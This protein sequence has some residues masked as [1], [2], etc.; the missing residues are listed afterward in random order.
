M[1]V[2]AEACEAASRGRRAQA[3]GALAWGL[4]LGLAGPATADDLGST[5]ITLFDGVGV[6]EDITEYALD[7]DGLT[8]TED[9]ILGLAIG[10]AIG[11]LG[12]GLSLDVETQAVYHHGRGSFIELG[13]ALVAR[14]QGLSLPEWLGGV[15][16]IDGFSIGTG[17]TVT[18]AIPPLE[19]DRGRIS[20]VLNQVVVEFLGGEPADGPLRPI[21][22]VH[23]RSGIFGLIEG[24]VGGSDYIGEGLQLR[25]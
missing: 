9:R 16:L 24:I 3:A 12:D 8:E 15:R 21:G 18:T 20:H 25:F 17:P 10:Q 7:R 14:W 13:A 4:G 23:H 5:M 1:S 2:E 6:L 11:W 19:A 22:R